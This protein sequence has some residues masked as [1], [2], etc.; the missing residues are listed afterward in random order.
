MKCCLC[1]KEVDSFYGYIACS[2]CWG[3]ECPQCHK[4]KP[5]DLKKE[6]VEQQRTEGVCY[7]DFGDGEKKC[8]TCSNSWFGPKVYCYKCSKKVEELRKKRYREENRKQMKS[9]IGPGVFVEA[10][11]IIALFVAAGLI[12]IWAITNVIKKVKKRSK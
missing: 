1:N 3:K 8:T 2:D 6:K 9:G 5:Y 11:V 10:V 4:I 12:V 7:C